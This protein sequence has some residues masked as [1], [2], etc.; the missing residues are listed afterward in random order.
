MPGKKPKHHRRKKCRHA[1]EGGRPAR[2]P[3]INHVDGDVGAAGKHAGRSHEER[4]AQREFGELGD[5]GDRLVGETAEE[6]IGRGDAHHCEE[7]HDSDA[8]EQKREARHQGAHSI[9]W[10]QAQKFFEVLACFSAS[11]FMVA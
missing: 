3:L 10:H 9:G 5:A 7:R 11:D 4:H 2:L 1:F 6:H 8:V